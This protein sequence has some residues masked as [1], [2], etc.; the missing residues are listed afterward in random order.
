VSRPRSPHPRRGTSGYRFAAP[1]LVGLVLLQLGPMIAA[2]GLA[3]TT[4][5]GL[6]DSTLQW[7][8]T[9]HFQGLPSDRLF[10]RALANSATYTAINVPAQLFAA[11]GMALLVKQSRRHRGFWATLYY[12]PHILGGV[13]T[14]L[15]WWWLL[16]PQVGPINRAIG[17]V[18]GSV[19]GPL[20]ALGL[21]TSRG[22]SLPPWLYSPAWAKPSVVIMNLWQAGA[23]MLIFL[24]ALL[25]GDDT[26]FEAAMLD[27]AG[28][29]R[30]FWHVTLPLIS[31]AILFNVVTGVAFSMQAFAP[32][33]LLQ[34]WQQQDSLLFYVL[35]IYRSAFEL[36]RF[37]YAAALAWV[38]LAILSVFTGTL[39]FL[40]RRWV[41]YDF[42]EGTL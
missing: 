7:V 36:H 16:N 23:G 28:R 24:A 12:L 19:D 20:A 41:H 27:G 3:M 15:I 10:S 30:R 25:R 1:W 18:Y 22:W 2:A 26:V 37:G 14:I 33:F 40:T 13:A 9:K 35:L 17:A 8:G 6:S 29:P 34:N 39:V 38:L 11:L 31:P 4:W 42:E 5:D 21:G 32:A